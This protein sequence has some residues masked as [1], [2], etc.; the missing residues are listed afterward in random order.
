MANDLE[1]KEILPEHYHAFGRIMQT[2]VACENMYA[3]IIGRITA[4]DDGNT[5]FLLSYAGYEAKK[6]II[7]TII[8]E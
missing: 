2:F 3:H 1:T 5:F 7:K 4:T 8:S 6:N